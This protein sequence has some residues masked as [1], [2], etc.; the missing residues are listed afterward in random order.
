[1]LLNLAF[2]FQPMHPA[3]QLGLA[4]PALFLAFRYW[5]ERWGLVGRGL[6]WLITLPIFILPWVAAN[7]PLDFTSM[8]A[9]ES[10]V[11]WVPIVALAALL[12]V[13]WWAL[14]LPKIASER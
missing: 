6:S 7:F 3:N 5:S 2:L 9:F 14:M 13:R 4:L 8:L 1:M 12:S 11:I 10:L